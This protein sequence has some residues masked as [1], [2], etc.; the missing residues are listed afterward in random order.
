MQKSL[1]VTGAA[2]GFLVLSILVWF[3]TQKGT[4]VPQQ[5]RRL[6]QAPEFPSGLDWLNTDTA[7]TVAGLRGKVVLLDFWT[8]C[9]INYMHVIPDLKALE[10]K[11]A[12]ALVVIGV[13]SAKFPNERGT[14]N[15]RQ[16]ILRHDIEHPVVNDHAFQIWQRY[17]VQAWPTL[18][19]IDP[20]GYLIGG[21]SGE[22]NFEL[23]DHI[24]GE[25]VGSA[26]AKGALDDTP[27][28]WS[29]EQAK[30]PGNALA[31]PG[32]VLADEASDQLF[33]ADS[34]HNRIVIA[35]L[36]GN[37][38]AVAGTGQ[39]GHAD[40]AFARA[41]FDHPQGMVID[42]HFLY[43]ADTENHLIR[44]LDLQQ[45]VVETL[46][47]TGQQARQAN[48]AGVGRQ[49][50]LNSPW[51]LV[52]V[53]RQ[54][55]IA[56]AGSHQIW[57][58][59]L[60]THEAQP[61]AGSGREGIT[62]GP[63]LEAAMA[64]PSGLTTDGM[65]LYVAD[66]ETSSIRAVD[67]DSPGRVETIVGEGLFDFG[68]QDGSGSHVRLQHPLG[69]AL[70]Q[71]RLYVADTYN[72]KI[73]IIAPNRKT[74]QTYLGSGQRGNRDGRAATFYEPG[75]LSI[76]AGKL[77]IA[78]TNNHAIRVV[79]LASGEVGGLRLRGLAVPEAVATFE[80]VT[81]LDAEPV[82][83]P[84]QPLSADATGELTIHFVLPSG[85]KVNP[86]AP[87]TY[88]VYVRGDGLEVPDAGRPLSAH[89]IELPLK[90]TWRTLPGTYRAELDIEATF[91]W[92]REDNTGVC[93]IQSARW[94]VP[95]AIG[96]TADNRELSVSITPRALAP[97]GSPSSPIL[98]LE[99][100]KQHLP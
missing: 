13:H 75:G 64:Q 69:L 83:M 86:V 74:S 81:W 62:D 31:F 22:G 57:V 98:P 70:H 49:V 61:F 12:Q 85:Y 90:L 43:V 89:A 77:Y 67:L 47:G 60:D 11:Y 40:G 30:T 25:V 8:Y 6:V 95:V 96:E 71:E 32:K 58:L 68:D 33:I 19:L 4:L 41:T 16:A 66:S 93:M 24:I 10:Q 27:R 59:H 26:R 5:S 20:S 76:A 54:L 99:D 23:L 80:G 92:C 15:I 65:R 52:L 17:G 37:V 84:T 38:L 51:D 79:S 36:D 28:R 87:I 78:D 35:T 94:H 72:H 56:M 29:L 2:L 97:A 73:K 9:C 21:V 91:Y 1:V 82:T 53:G 34:N 46:L 48:L 55:Y 50:A 45:R 39:E 88:A 100:R 14:D 3:V 63:R 7:L 44:R 42:G 18:A